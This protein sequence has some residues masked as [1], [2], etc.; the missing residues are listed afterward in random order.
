MNINIRKINANEIDEFRI[1]IKEVYDEYV[2]CDYSE[3]G[4]RTFY[5]FIEINKMRERYNN[6]N[7][8]IGAFSLNEMAGACEIR[9]GSH[10]ALFFVKK[11]Y[12]K[13][14]IGRKLF[15]YSL[16]IAREKT[17]DMKIM[18]VNSSPYALD[19]YKKL[20]FKVV[21]ELQEKD[22]IKFIPM[23]YKI[24]PGLNK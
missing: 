13:M 3:I 4:S 23:E 21:S 14:G 12:Q 5:D 11:S 9:N 19:I 22:G 24:M 10:I 17:P 1:L 6:G 20:G 15:D 16:K 18:T 8:M 7:L 2:A